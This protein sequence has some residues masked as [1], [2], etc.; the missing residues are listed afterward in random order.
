MVFDN[1]RVL[2]GRTHFDLIGKDGKREIHGGYVD[3][4]EVKSKINI[5]RKM[6]TD[7]GV[8]EVADL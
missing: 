5:L 2:H 1:L 8:H 6:L 4:D 7:K 3:W